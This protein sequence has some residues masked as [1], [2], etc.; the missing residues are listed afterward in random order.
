MGVGERWKACSQEPFVHINS[1]ASKRRELG[2]WW[3]NCFS[4]QNCFKLCNH[5]KIRPCFTPIGKRNSIPQN[6]GSHLRLLVLPA[7]T[8]WRVWLRSPRPSAACHS[9]PHTL[10]WWT[11]AAWVT[12]PGSA[13]SFTSR[14]H[15]IFSWRR[16]CGGRHAEWQTG[17]FR[18]TSDSLLTKK[19]EELKPH[20][21]LSWHSPAPKS[22]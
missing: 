6:P 18:N 7:Q 20:N 9:L 4:T 11:Q 10:H 17:F 1:N 22:A 21:Y 13:R 14:K 2:R 15:F 5:F 3:E 16:Q 8:H 12:Q 19:R